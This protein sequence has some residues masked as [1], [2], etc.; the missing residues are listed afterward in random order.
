LDTKPI[1][2]NHLAWKLSENLITNQEYY[3]VKVCKTTSGATII[4]AGINAPGG[5]QAG[6]ALTEICMGGAGQAKID[7][8]RYGDYEVPSVIITTDFPA[9][10]ALGSQF[11][12]WRIKDGENIAICS[13][14]ARALALK[15]KDL[16]AELNFKDTSD[17]AVIVIESDVMPSDVVVEKVT[18][19]CQVKPEKLILL[20][21]PTASVAGLVQVVGR[22]VET[23]IH[24]L[25]NCGLD[26]K[27]I[28]YASGYAPL[29]A[30]IKDFEVAMARTNDVL[31]YGGVVHYIVDYEDEAKLQS[32]LDQA[33]SCAAKNYGKPFLEIF[34]EADKDFYKIDTKLFAPAMLMINNKRT[35]KT[36]KAGQ[37]NPKVLAESLG[38]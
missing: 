26:P 12:G 21:A 38:F 23:G 27:E 20:V 9:V 1:S 35:G 29:P 6:I 34:R 13:G 10:A 2:V 11:A 4:D 28:Q 3:G 36:L 31:L 19:G 5:Y 30:L 32:I 24:K 18:T 17:K 25:H 33:P 14:P 37:I 8:K 22:I 16:Y 15:P 7:F